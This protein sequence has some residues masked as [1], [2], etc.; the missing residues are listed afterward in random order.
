MI[1]AVV[2]GGKGFI[3][4]KIVD[5]LISKGHYVIV[6]DI[7]R[8]SKENP[9]ALYYYNDIT[10]PMYNA[11][12]IFENAS[13]VFHLAA[14]IYV[15]KS[16]QFPDLF[17]NVNENGTKN[18]LDYVVEY[19]IKSFIF[20]STS[21]IYGNEITGQSKEYD[22]P[23]CLNAYSLSKYNAELL[24]KEYSE[25]YGINVSCLRYFNVYGDGQHETGQ[26]A[27][28]LGT[29]LKQYRDNLPL[30][31]VGDGLQKRDFVNV[32]D[33]AKANYKA[34]MNNTS[35]NI[36]NIGSGKNISIIDLAK[37]ISKDISF[38]ESRA[39]E[40]RETLADI[41]KAKI[42]LSWHPEIDLDAY[43]SNLIVF[44]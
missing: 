3:G 44:Q 38:I 43:I 33:V 39:G 32:I 22:K 23:N 21:A 8:E 7:D 11:K 9:E 10:K 1:K 12:D 20:S 14:E 18:I 5:Y 40:C 36:Y 13:V 25:K 2:T 31:V 35:F 24:C 17:K 27:P 29:F 37:S 34:F 16:L 42:L 4:K 6:I 15:Q 26:Y 28:A 30:T 41:N 19:N